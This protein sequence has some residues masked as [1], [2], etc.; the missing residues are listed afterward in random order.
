M[1]EA[2]R[3]EERAGFVLSQCDSV[4]CHRAEREQNRRV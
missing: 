2:L 4:I 3:T 1:A